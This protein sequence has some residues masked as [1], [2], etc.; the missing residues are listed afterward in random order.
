[1][2]DGLDDARA[3]TPGLHLDHPELLAR[4]GRSEVRRVRARRPDSPETT[5]I[6]KTFADAGENWAREAA[7]LAC[8]PADAPAVRL[9]AAGPRP[10]IVIMSDAGDGPSV[11]DALLGDDP[12]AAGEAVHAWAT[13]IGRLHRATLGARESFRVELRS[14][15]G[16]LMLGESRMSIM[17]DEAAAALDDLFA[18][19]D[20]RVPSGALAELR[21]LPRRL[22]GE[23]A[24]AL[25]PN[26]ACPDNNVRTADGLVLVDFEG[27]Q[28]RHVAWDVA[29]LTV[30]WPS[31]WCSWRMPREVTERAIER[32]RATVEDGLPYVRTGQ[33]RDD[34]TAAA[35]AWT[36]VS[37]SWFLPSALRDDAPPWDPD[38]PAPTRRAVI[39]HRLEAARRTTALP[40]LAELAGR[41]R[42]ALV[43]RW[44]ELPLGFAPA[45]AGAS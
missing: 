23:D 44:G 41:L 11:A 43:E 40:E 39:L 6:V 16:E 10:P 21:E 8:L 33:F 19:L 12:A 9:V 36:F 2:R 34:V 14:R 24:G 18:R 31:C 37:A 26:D 28:W 35:V 20:M 42:A 22:R 45:F 5:V 38:R 27:A 7:A 32:Y 29:Y 4:G 17:A 30:P 13:A 3:L 25:S 15:S 1:M